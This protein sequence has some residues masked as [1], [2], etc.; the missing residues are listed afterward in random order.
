MALIVNGLSQNNYLINNPIKIEISDNANNMQRLELLLTNQQT[1]KSI[2]LPSIYTYANKSEL[3]INDAIKSIF[4]EPKNNI[5]YDLVFDTFLTENANKIN[6]KVT[7][8][9]F[10][11]SV[12][13]V[14]ILRNYI[15]G[16]KYTSSNNQRVSNNTMLKVTETLPYWSGYPFAWYYL[17]SDGLIQKRP[18]NQLLIGQYEMLREK[19]CSSKYLVFLNS[20]GGFSSWLFD[21]YENTYDTNHIGIVNNGFNRKDLGSTLEYGFSV[22]G[23]VPK[24]FYPII[25]D[26]IASPLIFEYTK[27]SEGQLDNWRQIYNDNNNT[28]DNGVKEVYNVDLKFKDFQ[29][30]NT[31]LIW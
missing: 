30:V 12:G 31:S 24:R 17:T 7:A 2:H 9:Y 25:R 20:S 13:Q 14:E 18:I 11:G 1:G 6:L 3:L 28:I 19:S 21:N 15:R 4:T 8:H 10:D 23:K 29:N 16:H 26:L 27:G 5:N 22:F